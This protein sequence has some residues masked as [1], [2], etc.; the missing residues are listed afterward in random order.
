[1]PKPLA[2][3][4]R[5]P[6]HRHRVSYL[7]GNSDSFIIDSDGNKDA[8]KISTTQL[9]L[10]VSRNCTWIH[11]YEPLEKWQKLS[12]HSVKFCRTDFDH[13][14]CI[15]RRGQPTVLTTPTQVPPYT[16]CSTDD[17]NPFATEFTPKEVWAQLHRCSNMVPGPDRIRYTHWKQLDKG[18]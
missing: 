2:R 16:E 10:R 3:E 1:M 8:E 13:F 18:G 7:H 11:E 14:T 5:H 12:R 17:Q 4:P 6:T 9:Q 15:F